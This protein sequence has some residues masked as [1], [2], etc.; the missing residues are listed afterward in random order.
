MTTMARLSQ[1]LHDYVLETLSAEHCLIGI[2]QCIQ[3]IHRFQ[4]MESKSL[5]LRKA[6]ELTIGY[7]PISYTNVYMN[8]NIANKC[9]SNRLETVFP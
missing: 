2:T 1:T 5:L 6:E 9:R 4:C 8:D 7:K 3:R